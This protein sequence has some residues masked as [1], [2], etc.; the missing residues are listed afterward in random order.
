VSET[1]DDLSEL[2]NKCSASI[3]QL[4][5]VVAVALAVALFAEGLAKLVEVS[6]PALRAVSG[7]AILVVVGAV[8]LIGIL[9][10]TRARFIRLL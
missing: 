9:T 6:A 10:W 1:R 3:K 7:I 4:Q 2:I 5:R 8:F